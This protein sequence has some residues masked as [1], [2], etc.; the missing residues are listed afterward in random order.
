MEEENIM[1]LDGETKEQNGTEDKTNT[2]NE[3]VGDTFKRKLKEKKNEEM[4]TVGVRHG[5]DFVVKTRT[6]IRRKPKKYKCPICSLIFDTVKERDENMREDHEI[7]SFKCEICGNQFDTQSSLKRH[8]FEHKPGGKKYECKMCGKMFNFSS[9]LKRH[10]GTHSEVPLYRC[11]YP[12]CISVNGW[13]DMCD[14]NRHMERHRNKDEI[15]KCKDCNYEG[16]TKK[17]LADHRYKKHRTEN[18]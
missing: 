6:I 13:R 9:L 11:L 3:I 15:Y 4:I 7:N 10:E 2:G 18:N 8:A 14:Y 1:G 17:N 5:E 16:V 12:E